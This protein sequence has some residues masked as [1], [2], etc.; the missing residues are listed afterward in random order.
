MRKFKKLTITLALLI[1]AVTGA[2][3]QETVTVNRDGENNKWTFTMPGG[4]VELQ[5][6]YYAESNLFLSKDALADM[7]N[8]AVTAGKDP[9]AFGDDGKSANTVTEGTPDRKSVV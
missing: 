7:T 1:M 9:V 2:W 5:V 6:E 8:I 4:N 3:A